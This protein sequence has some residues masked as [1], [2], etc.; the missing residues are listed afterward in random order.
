MSA[1]IVVLRVI[2]AVHSRQRNNGKT[3]N[4][5]SFRETLQLSLLW[6]VSRLFG[7]W[8][9]LSTLI[10]S[11]YGFKLVCGVVT[12]LAAE[13]SRKDGAGRLWEN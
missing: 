8:H 7:N 2:V 10:R 4:H 5:G 3:P 11:V 9:V 13:K 6:L 1:I 12:P